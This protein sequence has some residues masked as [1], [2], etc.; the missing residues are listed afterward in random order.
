M[1]GERSPLNIYGHETVGS[2]VSTGYA[3]KQYFVANSI[4]CSPS[5][6]I[7]GALRGEDRDL[8]TD[9]GDYYQGIIEAAKRGGRRAVEDLVYATVISAGS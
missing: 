1:E 3:Q 6:Y 4:P 9:I 5:C 7:A 2:V 8:G